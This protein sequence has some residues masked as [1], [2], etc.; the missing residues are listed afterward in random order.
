MFQW[1]LLVCVI[2][3]VITANVGGNAMNWHFRFGYTVASLLLF[4]IIWGLFGGRWSRFSAFIYAPRSVIAYLQGRGRPEHSVGHTPLGAAS[5]FALLVFL[6]A[7]VAT[8]MMSDDEIA[9]AG[10]LTR[11][12]SNAT[13]SLA[14]T[15]HAEIGK[16]ILL[17]LIVLHLAAII[18]Y[19][20]RK[21][22]LVSAMVSGDKQLTMPMLPSRDD[23][24]TRT[25]AAVI[26]AAC[27]SAVYWV[28]TLAAP[29]F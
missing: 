13:V 19:T 2:C 22:R 11:F 21:E 27:A 28:S 9:F 1:T 7:L 20:R 29:A 23:A 5:V 4:R 17:A 26:F 10:P 25:L 15:Y 6:A 3:L 24:L 16:F 8:G 14:T 18:Y 12:V